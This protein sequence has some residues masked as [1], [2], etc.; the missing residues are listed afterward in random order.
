MPAAAVN[1]LNG[2][3]G[4]SLF[5]FEDSRGGNP[6]LNDYS[7]YGNGGNDGDYENVFVELGCKVYEVNKVSYKGLS[8]KDLE[9]AL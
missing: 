2:S 3:D 5:N 4:S 6:N 1:F 7:S 8:G 9:A